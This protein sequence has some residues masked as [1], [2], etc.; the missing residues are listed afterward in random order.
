MQD[1]GRRITKTRSVQSFNNLTTFHSPVVETSIYQVATSQRKNRR[2]T[3]RLL[4]V[5]ISDDD[6]RETESKR[7]GN[8][9]Q[10]RGK[11]Q[12]LWTRACQNGEQDSGDRGRRKLNRAREDCTGY[13]IHIWFGVEVEGNC[14][15]VSSRELLVLMGGSRTTTCPATG[16]GRILALHSTG[17][18]LA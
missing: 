10:R 4:K 8:F 6:I 5:P 3:S 13:S 7:G 12:V 11:P 14:R 16:L 15:G 17:L 1:I 2:K 9:T 18:A